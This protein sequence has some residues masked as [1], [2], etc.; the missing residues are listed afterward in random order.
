[1]GKT[2]D[3][4]LRVRAGEIDEARTRDGMIEIE[5]QQMCRR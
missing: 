2:E 5:G 4:R 3:E 1:M